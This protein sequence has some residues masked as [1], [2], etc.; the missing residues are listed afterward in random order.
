MTDVGDQDIRNPQ[1]PYSAKVAI[2]AGYGTIGS[3]IA[4]ELAKDGYKVAVITRSGGKSQVPGIVHLQANLLDFKEALNCVELAENQIGKCTL[5]VCCA[6][7]F[8][9]DTPFSS[10]VTHDDLSLKPICGVEINFCR[11]VAPRLRTRREGAIVFFT[12]SMSMMCTDSPGMTGFLTWANGVTGMCDGLPAELRQAGV[13]VSLLL[14]GLVKGSK[15]SRKTMHLMGKKSF[16]PELAANED[17]WVEPLDISKT[18]KFVTDP[19]ELN[20]NIWEMELNPQPMLDKNSIF[21]DQK[22]VEEMV[23][24]LPNGFQ[25]NK[26]A[27]ITGSG[28]GIGKGVVLELCRAGYHIAAMTRTA[29]DLE[30]LEREC[31][32]VNPMVKFLGL[33]LDV[34]DERALEDGVLKVVERFGTISLVVS[35]AGTNGEMLWTSTSLLP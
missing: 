16:N 7:D 27:L 29:K 13:R 30:I 28:K 22:R 31:E 25:D 2:V 12:S 8:P 35:N 34:T 11:A 10:P 1:Q 19:K 32:Q 9:I 24:R 20:G 33:P 3:C 26:V 18:V 6:G 23:Q 17:K 5:A 21:T 15:F 4:H 14:L